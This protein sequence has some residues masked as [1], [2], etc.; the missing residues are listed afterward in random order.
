MTTGI[1]LWELVTIATHT[2]SVN[3]GI[4]SGNASG[5]CWSWIFLNVAQYVPPQLIPEKVGESA[6]NRERRE[7]D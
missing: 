7:V 5:P 3:K 6:D 2:P 4:G 1:A